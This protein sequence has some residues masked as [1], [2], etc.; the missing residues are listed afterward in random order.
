MHQTFWCLYC[1]VLCLCGY[2]IRNGQWLY[3]NKA[4]SN[5]GRIRIS[6]D[7]N[8][9]AGIFYIEHPLQSSTEISLWS[10]MYWGMT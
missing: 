5:T 1:N 7:N 8:S 3:Y 2:K 6:Q 10:S 9:L 4:G